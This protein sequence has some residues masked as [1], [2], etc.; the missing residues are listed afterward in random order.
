[1]KRRLFVFVLA[2]FIAVS[3]ACTVGGGDDAASPDAI[4]QRTRYF[5]PTAVELAEIP[6]AV[7]TPGVSAEVNGIVLTVRQT[8]ADRYLLY[9][10]FDVEVPEET[11][12]I[13]D[14]SAHSVELSV[15]TGLSHGGAEFLQLLESSAR[16]HTY[17][18]VFY[19][20][21]LARLESGDVT[22]RFTGLPQADNSEEGAEISVTWPF[23][24]TDLSRT[25]VFTGPYTLCG[26]EVGRVTVTLSP[27]SLCIQLEEC[28]SRSF[29]RLFWE[30]EIEIELQDGAVWTVPVSGDLDGVKMATEGL[31]HAM[32]FCRLDHVLSLA[33][34][35]QVYI[36]GTA[37][38]V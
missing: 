10:L 23:D 11:D 14:A 30:T 17:L 24:Y 1:M 7:R 4:W 13:P 3:A 32:V 20:A 25:E 22:L 15:K 6:E 33:D 21:P 9:V 34:T 35:T 38:Q 37:F 12:Y 28:R 36:D 8:I 19:R 31:K 2:L 5:H 29:I 18:L 27:L 26:A 16:R